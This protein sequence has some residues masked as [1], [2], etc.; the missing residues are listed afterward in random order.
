MKK[1]LLVLLILLISKFESFSQLKQ[2]KWSENAVIYEVNLRQ[3][4]EAGTFNEFAKSLPR[5]KK[6]G[7]DVLWFMPLHPIGLAN[8]KGSL[9]SYYSVQDYKG[10]DPSYGTSN[11]FKA[12]VK[13][14][15]SLGMKVLIDWVANHSAWDNPWISK[16][17]EWYVRNEKGEIQTQYD[18]TDVAK[19]NYDSK[20]MRNAMTDAMKYW[21]TEFDIDGF[22]CDV[23]FLVP[24][25]FWEENRK[26][27]EQV[28]PV[29][30][31]AEM[32]WNTDITK[33][34]AT[35]F[36]SAFNANYGWNFMGV[37]AD[38]EK[39]KKTL[40]N[41]RDEMQVNYSRFPKH[42]HK[43]LFLTNHDENSWNETLDERYGK[44][45][46]LYA[47]MVYTMPQS[48]PLIYSGEEVG[49][50]RKLLFFEKDPITKMEWGNTG[51][52]GFYQSMTS[53]HHKVK[54]LR[55]NQP[56]AVF[57]ELKIKSTNGKLYGY[58]RKCNGHEANVL[59]NFDDKQSN[60]VVVNFDAKKAKF[61]TYSN[62]KFILEMNGSITL[63]AHSFVILHK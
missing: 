1:L 62:S 47:A 13:K 51:R 42:L 52:V 35:Y 46:Q 38:I 24:L 6:M 25:D 44:N 40:A 12:V 19:L 36:V 31:L 21:L 34:P 37:T 30:M 10:I 58:T 15:H 17:P 9:G 53:L 18:W 29:Y 41:F 50:K 27:L 61:K 49:L 43:M 28:K 55:N 8:R 22:R 23:A 33:N 3:Y 14:A 11:D 2:P 48:I 39:G 32:E 57:E 16:H 63:P 60:L 59:Y 7:V 5:L 45:W 20:E 56:N 4:S 26:A 54:A